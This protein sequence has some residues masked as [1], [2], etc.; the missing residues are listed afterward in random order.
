M[1]RFLIIVWVLGLATLF[2]LGVPLLRLFDAFQPMV[3]AL[4]IMVAAVFV[5]LNRG[6]PALE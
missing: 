2:A 1:A 3:V 4:S 6:M 5:R